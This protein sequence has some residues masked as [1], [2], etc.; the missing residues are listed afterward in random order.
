VISY[1]GNPNSRGFYPRQR[2]SRQR[3]NLA[4]AGFRGNHLFDA[5][6][7]PCRVYRI[8]GRNTAFCI[9][10]ESPLQQLTLERSLESQDYEDVRSSDQRWLG[11]RECGSPWSAP[12]PHGMAYRSSNMELPA[13]ITRLR[14]FAHLTR[15]G[16]PTFP[17]SK[18]NCREIFHDI[19][20]DIRTSKHLVIPQAI[21]SLRAPTAS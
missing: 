2:A 8:E 7:T 4:H 3:L 20:A 13:R 6:S 12:A 14:T 16:A 19:S 11:L 17:A 9:S 18:A 15:L 10:P 5:L 1:E 21:P